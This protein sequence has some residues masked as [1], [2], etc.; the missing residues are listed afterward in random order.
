[1]SET[2]RFNHTKIE[3]RKIN[4]LVGICTGILADGTLN[5]AEIHFIKAWLDKNKAHKDAW[6]INILYAQI[7]NILEDNIIDEDERASLIATLAELADFSPI[8]EQPSTSLPLCNPAPE[9]TY[10]N[11][12]FVL[13]GHF[14]LGSRNNCE[15][16]ISHLGGIPQRTITLKTD[17]LII[18]D[19][20][21]SDWAHQSFGRKIERAV[22]LRTKNGK[23]HI[24]SET[25]WA[26]TLQL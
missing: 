2:S 26:K 4:E 7:T 9:I 10:D 13:T 11:K 18:G 24:I 3:D 17:Y 25:H 8:C 5:D 21:S 19:K 12:V 6:P 14:Y 1:M 22:D 15:R 16:E 23:P 20:G